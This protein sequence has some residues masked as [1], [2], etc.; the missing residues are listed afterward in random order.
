MIIAVEF[1]DLREAAQ[2]RQQN[3]GWLFVS[4]SHPTVAWFNAR[5]FTPTSITRHPIAKGL[6]G[7]LVADN[8]YLGD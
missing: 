8:R 5:A 4:A 2:Y 1:N 3:G 6:S 7:E